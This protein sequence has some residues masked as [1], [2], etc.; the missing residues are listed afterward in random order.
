M[1]NSSELH[2]RLKKKR[3]SG[4]SRMDMEFGMGSRVASGNNTEK[5]S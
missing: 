3:I 1:K 4:S 5:G 2:T